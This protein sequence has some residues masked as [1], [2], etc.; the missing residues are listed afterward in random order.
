MTKKQPAGVRMESKRSASTHARQ[1]ARLD[2]VAK[3]KGCK[4]AF[5]KPVIWGMSD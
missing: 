5:G 1:F 4:M 2:L 3:P